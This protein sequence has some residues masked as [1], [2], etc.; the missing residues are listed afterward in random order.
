MLDLVLAFAAG[1]FVGWVLFPELARLAQAKLSHNSNQIA[2]GRFR[3]FEAIIP[4]F[5]Q[6]TGKPALTSDQRGSNN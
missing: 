1:P 6:T 2:R 3:R 5:P 4:V